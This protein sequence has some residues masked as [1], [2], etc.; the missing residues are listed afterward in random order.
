MLSASCE[1]LFPDF[2]IL[3]SNRG[4]FKDLSGKGGCRNRQSTS[5]SG[6]WPG[7][8][9]APDRGSAWRRRTIRLKNARPAELPRSR[10][11]SWRPCP[12]G[13]TSIR[14]RTGRSPNVNAEDPPCDRPVRSKQIVEGL[15]RDSLPSDKEQLRSARPRRRLKP[16]R[17][18]HDVSQSQRVAS[19]KPCHDTKA[20]LSPSNNWSR[21]QLACPDRRW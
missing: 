5:V 12:A 16:E 9:W 4:R 14:A 10:G 1:R 15:R 3:R 19:C 7:I 11:Q 8:V 17:K 13:P 20:C 2:S 18:W 6:D 21:R